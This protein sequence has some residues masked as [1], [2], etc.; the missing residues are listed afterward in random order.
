MWN[1]TLCHWA[2]GSSVSGSHGF[3]ILQMLESLRLVVLNSCD[4]EGTTIRRKVRGHLPNH[5]VLYP[6]THESF[7]MWH[8]LRIEY[9]VI[10]CIT[11][12]VFGQRACIGVMRVATCIY[13]YIYAL[14]N[15]GD[16]F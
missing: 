4:S 6:G 9:S 14:L 8:A 15:D 3:F 11:S 10:I 13:I 16:T 5:T 2:S 12:L 1:V 7:L